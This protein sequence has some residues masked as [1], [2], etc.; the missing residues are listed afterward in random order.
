M[1]LITGVRELPPRLAASLSYEEAAYIERVKER[2][3]PF[4]VSG[5]FASLAGPERDDPIRRQFMPD[6]REEQ[7]D[8][9]ALEDPLGEARYRVLPR[10]VHQYRDRALLKT[11]GLCGGCCRFCFRRV[12]MAEEAPFIPE[13]E[14]L[15]VFAWLKTRPEIREL[16]LSGGDPLCAPEEAERLISRIRGEFPSLRIRVC[17]RIPITDPLRIDSAFIGFLASRRP[18]RMAVHINHPRELSPESRALLAGLAGAGIPVHVQTVLLKGINDNAETLANLFEDCLDLG[19]SPYYLFQL[20]LAPGTAHFRVP[21]RKG[22]AL[23]RELAALLSGLALPSYALDLPGG[24]GKIRLHEG[25]IAGEGPEGT[26]L[27][28]RDRDGRLWPYPSG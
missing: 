14:V 13:E 7:A 10:L 16:L 8:P 6:P 23:Y 4:A 25:V 18:L 2:G 20:D 27:L 3:L 19:L 5:H 28:L 15:A 11:C 24:G 9:F 21:L 22:L 1:N 17:T 12:W 26:T